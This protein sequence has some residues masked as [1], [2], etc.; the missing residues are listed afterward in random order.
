VAATYAL[1]HPSRVERLALMSAI[2][3]GATFRLSRAAR[4]LTLPGLGEALALCGCAP[5]Y[6]AALARC[7]HRPDCEAVEFLVAWSY[8]ARTRW[9][10]RAAYLAAVRSLRADLEQR[11]REYRRALATLDLPVLLIHGR[12][13]PV[14]PPAHCREV[15]TML[16]RA[17]VRW[18]DACGHFPQFEQAEAVNDWMGE[19]LVGRPAAR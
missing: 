12:Q 5:I 4:V 19:F 14:V 13:D 2:V 8:A 9:D 1:I 16:P 17:G 10:A 15:A 7:F 11:G 18:V 6:R 3:P